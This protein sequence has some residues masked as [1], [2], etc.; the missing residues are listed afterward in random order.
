MHTVAFNVLRSTK[1]G[2]GGVISLRALWEYALVVQ[3]L[4]CL[5]R[6]KTCHSMAA[7]HKS[8]ICLSC[9]NISLNT[10]PRSKMQKRGIYCVL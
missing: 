2:F 7:A 5:E 8:Q 4:E 9:S 10:T 1:R 6:T 3:V